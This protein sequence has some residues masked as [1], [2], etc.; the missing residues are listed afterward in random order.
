MDTKTVR[1]IAAQRDQ[2]THPQTTALPTVHK[3]RQCLHSPYP[4]PGAPAYATGQVSA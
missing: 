3:K 4:T 1:D 2:L